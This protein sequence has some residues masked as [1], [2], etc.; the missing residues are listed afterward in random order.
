MK[1]VVGL[2]VV[3]FTAAFLPA[4]SANEKPAIAIIDTAIDTAQVNVFYEVCLME[5]KRCPNKQSY[6]EGAGSAHMPASKGFEHGT[7]MVQIAQQLNPNMNIVFIR[8]F[9]DNAKTGA[10]VRNAA[11][12][13]STVR[14]A[15]EWVAKNKTKF[16][17]VAVS[18]ALGETKF[19]TRG[20]YCPVNAGVRNAIISL[21]NLGVAS[22][23]AAGNRYDYARV[24]YPACISEAVAVSSVGVRGNVERY[25]NRSA[26]TDFFALGTIN[27]STGTSAATVA[28]ASSWAKNYKGNFSDTYNYFKSISKTA[29]TE[30]FSTNLFVDVN[31]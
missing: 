20:S 18:A 8:I 3:L 5:E 16:N 26:E 27:N 25:S 2:L 9:P 10:I 17:I 21:Q 12:V 28:L 31:S 19:A 29:S 24:D 6:M 13:N 7:Q 22:I 14:Q 11:N 4:V 15:M 1:K 30:G 23:F